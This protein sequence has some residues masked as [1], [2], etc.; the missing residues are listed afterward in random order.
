M[1]PPYLAVVASSSMRLALLSKVEDAHED[2]VWTAA[3]SGP[4][5]LLTGKDRTACMRMMRMGRE[6]GMFSLVVA[7][8]DQDLWT[9]T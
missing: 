9:R 7:S 1:D 5:Q 3:W 6:G 2:A 4:E 8:V